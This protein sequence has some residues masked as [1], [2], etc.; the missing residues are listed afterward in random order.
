MSD[1]VEIYLVS[2]FFLILIVVAV[3]MYADNKD[4]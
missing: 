3:I 2:A 1:M 4:D